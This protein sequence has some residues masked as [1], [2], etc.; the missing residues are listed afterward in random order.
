MLLVDLAAVSQSIF[1]HLIQHSLEF[2]GTEAKEVMEA[3]CRRS[4]GVQFPTRNIWS[5]CLLFLQAVTLAEGILEGGC[6]VFK[7]SL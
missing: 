4:F 2:N 3:K 6:Q 5:N 7:I 1:F